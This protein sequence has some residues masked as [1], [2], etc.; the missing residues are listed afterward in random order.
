MSSLSKIVVTGK[1]VRNPEKRFTGTNLPITSFTI[2]IGA[3]NE[4]KLVRVFAIGKLGETTANSVKKDQSVVVEGKLQTAAVKTESGVEKKI[5]EINA[6]GLEIIGAS[7][8]EG[9]SEETESVANDLG[10]L[11]DT[12]SDELIGEDEIPF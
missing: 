2:N 4:E 10:F 12:S 1:V 5:V 7:L 8:Q 6:Q 3:E 9:S 11:E